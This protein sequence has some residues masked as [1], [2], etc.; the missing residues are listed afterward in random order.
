MA[1]A[2]KTRWRWLKRFLLVAPMLLLAGLGFLTAYQRSSIGALLSDPND[3]VWQSQA[4]RLGVQERGEKDGVL[5]KHVIRVL[6]EDGSV[7]HESTFEIDWDAGLTGGGFV[8]AMQADSDP[9]LEVVAWA[10]NTGSGDE[11]FQPFFLD[12]RQG[13]VTRQPF[14]EASDGA[15]GLAGRW[16][17]AHVIR[18][19]EI[20]V[21]IL[22]SVVYYLFFGLVVGGIALVRRLRKR[23]GP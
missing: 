10:A 20:T 1:E 18:D 12:H 11:R 15:H 8:K 6:R 16:R 7:A 22:L 4:A 14:A 21:V 23:T 17:Q 5:S 19:L 9:E 13:E 2:R 3:L